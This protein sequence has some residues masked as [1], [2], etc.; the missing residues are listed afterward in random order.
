M[1]KA[2]AD[3]LAERTVLALLFSEHISKATNLK[4]ELVPAHVPMRIFPTYLSF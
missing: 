1:C 4:S 3:A 2:A